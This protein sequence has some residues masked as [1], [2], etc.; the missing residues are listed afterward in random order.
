MASASTRAPAARSLALARSSSLWLMPLSQGT[1]TMPT[2]ATALIS[3][4]SWPAPEGMS[5]EGSSSRSAPR[6]TISTISFGKCT[7]GLVPKPFTVTGQGAAFSLAI[8]STASPRSFRTSMSGWRKSMLK[9]T[10]PGTT[11]GEPG[12]TSMRPTVKRTTSSGSCISSSSAAITRTAADSASLR[13]ARGVVPAWASSPSISIS[14][15]RMP[16][17]EVTTP[18]CSPSASSRGPCSIWASR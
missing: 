7:G 4:A 3:P 18:I 8:R 6:R 14:K 13:L 11:L 16:W 5:I 17:I 15:R 10:W 1:N 2:G 9:C 12:E